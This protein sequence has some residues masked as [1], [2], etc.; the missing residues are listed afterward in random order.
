[1][2]AVRLRSYP[3]VVIV[4]ITNNIVPTP[5]PANPQGHGGE[6]LLLAL[7][8]MPVKRVN[9]SGWFQRKSLATAGVISR[10]EDVSDVLLRMPQN[11]NIVESARNI[12]RIK[13]VYEKEQVVDLLKSIET[14]D[15][16]PAAYIQPE[17]IHSARP[18]HRY[19]RL[20]R[21][22]V[23]DILSNG[24]MEKLAGY[25]DGDKHVQ[26]NP[27][28]GEGLSG[29]GAALEAMPKQGITMNTTASTKYWGKAVLFSP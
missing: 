23:D 29:L 13:D 11:W 2:Y 14:G 22:F 26:H 17:Q 12:R 24:R 20:V 28:I 7:A 4:S 5:R 8:A 9:L 3:R 25:F 21:T 19:K 15:A 1:M 6:M 16:K 27:Q 10:T 18:E